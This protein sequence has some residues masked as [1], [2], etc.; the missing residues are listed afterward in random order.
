[1]ALSI[2]NNSHSS[3]SSVSS[4][5]F[6]EPFS[7]PLS[8]C[9]SSGRDAS[10][11][12]GKAK[13]GVLGSEGPGQGVVTASRSGLGMDPGGGIV[14]AIS[15]AV[16]SFLLSLPLTSSIASLPVV[17]VAVAVM[18][19]SSL[20][21]VEVEV[22]RPVDSLF[23]TVIVVIV[24]VVVVVVTEVVVVVVMVVALAVVLMVAS[25]RAVDNVEELTVNRDDDD[26]DDDARGCDGDGRTPPAP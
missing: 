3:S 20:P 15:Q 21:L 13:S 18:P 1:M 12:A 25:E 5:P 7:E 24:E 6:S 9:E 19:P 26:D 4:D 8:S 10:A 17:A 16:L 22:A 14:I 23:F 2:S 11:G